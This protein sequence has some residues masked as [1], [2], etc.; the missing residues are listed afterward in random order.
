MD[1]STILR[2]EVLATEERT[3][4]IYESP[5]RLAK[6][7]AQ[8][9]E[10]MGNER[11]AAVCREISKLH[12]DTRRGTLSELAQYYTENGVYKYTIGESNSYEEIQQIK[13]N[14]SEK[15]KEAFVVAFLNGKKI[16]TQ[17][18]VKI[19]QKQK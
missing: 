5:Y 4:I 8:L 6:T 7:L 19:S 2:L 17:E 1:T 3:M 18:A 11:E 16:N 13:K 12:A 10:V 14:L 9:A 15:F